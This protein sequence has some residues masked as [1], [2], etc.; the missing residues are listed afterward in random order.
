VDDDE[1]ACLLN[2]YFG[3]V[4]TVE[5]RTTIPDPIT[6]FQG[7]VLFL[8]LSGADVFSHGDF[9]KIKFLQKQGFIFF[10]IGL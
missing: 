8:F 10:C 3:T 7:P 4:F 6:L 2:T 5:D 9:A 1:A